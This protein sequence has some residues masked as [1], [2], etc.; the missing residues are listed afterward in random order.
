M[1]IH[2][3]PGCALICPIEGC[4][5]MV[6]INCWGRMQKHYTEAHQ[7]DVKQEWSLGWD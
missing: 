3:D 6:K 1:T 2:P 4:G 7:V 5:Y